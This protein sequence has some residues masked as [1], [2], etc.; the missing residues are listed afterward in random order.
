VALD[1]PLAFLGARVSA[2]PY[3]PG[4][5]VGMDT[6]W[7]VE[8]DPPAGALSI[9]A[10]LL[11]A[12]GRFLAG[13]DGLSV[14]SDQWQSGDVIVQ[15]HA[16]LV[17]PEALPDRYWLQTGVYWLDSSQRWSVLARGE[18]VGDRLLVGEVEVE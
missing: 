14:P 10:H 6:Y 11:T 4:A 18:V 7:R 9:M 16:L 1:G 2:G 12:D 15:H 17:P 3:R 8:S 5:T 13:D